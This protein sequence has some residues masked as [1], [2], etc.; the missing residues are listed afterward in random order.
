MP[1][2]LAKGN[3]EDGTGCVRRVAGGIC[4]SI[5]SADYPRS[6]TYTVIKGI[7]CLKS[8][9]IVLIEIMNFRRIY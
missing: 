6:L 4:E 8:K 2:I 5:L 9:R 7:Q 1:T 3:T